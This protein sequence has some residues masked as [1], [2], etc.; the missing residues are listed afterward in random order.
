MDSSQFS[1]TGLRSAAPRIFDLARE[2]ASLGAMR[3]ELCALAEQMEY[4]TFRDYN[5]LR[6][7]SIIRV[8]DCASAFRSMLRQRS[9]DRAGFSV[10][11]AIRDVA[12][13]VAR[14][15]L[16]PGFYADLYHVL[17]GLQGLGPG[18]APADAA[19]AVSR[20]EGRE[21]AQERSRQLDELWR[22]I[23][24][25]LARYG[26][27]LDHETRERRARRRE[28]IRGALGGSEQEWRD[29]RWQL[30]HV[31]R[32]AETLER[33]TTLSDEERRA[34]REAV[35]RRVPFGIT[36]HYLSLMY[37]EPSPDDRAI[38]AQVIPSLEYAR[39]VGEARASCAEDLDFM[40]ERDTSPVDLVTRRYP[41]IAIFKPYNTC[42]QICVYCQ[43][44]WE[45]DGVLDPGALAPEAQIAAALDWIREHPAIHE[46]LLTG[47]D[48]LA[49]ADGTVRRILDGIA[50]IPSVERIRIG[51]RTP[52]TLPMRFTDDLCA[53]LGAY[54]DPGRREVA[55]V[56][57]VQHPSEL[58]AEVVEAVDRLRRCGVSVYNQLVFTFFVSRR[59]EAAALRR[60]LRR[61]GIDPYYTFNTKGKEETGA[62]R[63]PIARLLQEQKEESRLM[64]G[65]ARTDEA[66]Y[67][68]PGMGKNYL[69]AR[70]HRNVLSI[71]PDG[72]RV[73]EYHPWE[74]NVSGVGPLESYVSADVPILEY[75]ERLEA[76]GEDASD[77]RTIW[78]YY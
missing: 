34:V 39:A 50:A 40:R 45:I 15:D 43:R 42:P 63:V 14:P 52:V 31:I 65:M 21:A 28:R 76:I 20:L 60:A 64:P 66:V 10:A 26:T 5:E 69:R 24:F 8:R 4:D 62:Y 1:A 22:G 49:M 68:V 56:T 75:L 41:A 51:T 25:R 55:V 18:E 6:E 12:R 17:L 57:H 16:A 23:E 29:W 70:Q 72:A 19:L 74:K 44:N 46:V 33:L 30:R 35:E 78:Y 9:D 37:D 54:R 58:T 36:P 48:P 53:L 73:Y 77:Y 38:R 61:A 2:A 71:L 13:G 3:G 11:Q 67:N 59:F 32:D 27:G 47:G 7:G